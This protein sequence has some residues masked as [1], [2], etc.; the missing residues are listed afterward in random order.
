MR[1]SKSKEISI[2]SQNDQLITILGVLGYQDADDL[3]FVTDQA[4]LDYHNSMDNVDAT[5]QFR[6]KFCH[7]SSSLI[8]LLERMLT[9]NPSLR[10]TT[11]DCLDSPIFDQIRDK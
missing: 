3:S 5:K 6:S 2:V 9:Y 8:D 4:A 7:T 1:E 10:P 11:Q